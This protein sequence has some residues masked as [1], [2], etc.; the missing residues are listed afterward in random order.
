MRVAGT[1]Q[2]V[3]ARV[4]VQSGWI[5]DVVRVTKG[6]AFAEAAGVG[7]TVLTLTDVGDF[8]E[9]EGR[10]QVMVSGQV[11][12]YDVVDPATN[13]ITLA[14]PLT[15][16]AAADDPADLFDPDV[17]GT[18]VV[19][20]EAKVMLDDSDPSDRPID[21]KIS[22]SLAQMLE[23]SGRGT[24]GEAVTLVRV[25][26]Y[27]WEIWQVDG[28]VAANLAADSAIAQA[29]SALDQALLALDQADLALAI[30]DGQ[31]D[32][33]YQ[34]SAP[35]ANGS[36]AHDD[37]TGD[38]W[39]DTDA[40]TDTAY[41]WLDRFWTLIGDASIVAALLAAQSAQTTADGKITLYVLNYAPTLLTH[42]NLGYGDLLRRT[43]QDNKEYYWD[44]DSWEPLLIG[45][46]ALEAILTGKTVRTS[47]GGNRIQMRD[48]GSA[49]TIEAYYG[50]VKVGYINPSS[51]GGWD[52][53][54][55]VQIRDQ[56][57][58]L[59]KLDIVT[60][61]AEISG[62]L[63][64][65]SGTSDFSGDVNM[66]SDAYVGG[67]LDVD[68]R[69]DTAGEVHGA[70]GFHDDGLAGGGLTAASIGN[71][72]RIVRTTSSQRYKHDIHDADLD[73][74]AILQLTPRAFKRT[75]QDD[76]PTDTTEYVGFI[77]EEVAA[78]E[79]LEHFVFHD[80]GDQPEGFHYDAF[81]AGLLA[82]CQYLD[83]RVTTLEE[84][85]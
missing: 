78:I 61:G 16:A 64:V 73:V 42:P 26:D 52:I 49:G 5:Q 54:G 9:G 12:D 46:D 82:L 40:A 41:R 80:A 77:A 72:G 18:V 10:T 65:I 22:H 6:H 43:D 38:I 76:E 74:A 67:Q 44:G 4:D 20:Y 27:R 7:D 45:D 79:G 21:V 56:L 31:V 83:Q 57:T 55:F 68:G 1:P 66:N 48:D 34:T 19:G 32:I 47:A 51:A 75:A 69:S 11:Y 85:S 84:A 29:D 15:V 13:T 30:S 3:L 81:T 58:L 53:D 8:I 50:G 37:D 2:P 71:G 63:D 36:T 35:W 33:H 25:G 62:G 39:V 59:A 23:E 28:K 14:D 70:Q 17:D 24:F 60:G